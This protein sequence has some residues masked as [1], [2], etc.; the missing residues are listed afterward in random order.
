MQMQNNITLQE[1]V[2]YPVLLYD[3]EIP[4]HYLMNNY[5]KIPKFSDL[6]MFAVI[7]LKFKQRGFSI[8]KFIQNVQIVQQTV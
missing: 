1:V 7:N 3:N 6:K 2:K 8:E 4:D 5:R